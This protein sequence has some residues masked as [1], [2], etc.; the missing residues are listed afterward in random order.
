MGR[1]SGEPDL[2]QKMTIADA[3]FAKGDLVNL[4]SG[5]I[6]LAATGDSALVGVV[7]E[8]ISGGTGYE[9]HLMDI[10]G[11][12]PGEPLFKA[13]SYNPNLNFHPMRTETLYV[14]GLSE[15][16][17]GMNEY[18]IAQLDT[19][20]NLVRRSVGG[21]GG[22]I[23]VLDYARPVASPDDIWTDKVFDP[24]QKGQPRFAR[25]FGMANILFSD[26][27]VRAE[28]PEDIDPIAPTAAMKWWMP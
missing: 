3:A 15:T 14:G 12:K 17:Y 26:G 1:L 19:L 9:D 4:E 22:K 18:A 21:A 5:Q 25:H 6:D 10:T 20:G 23:L 28:R 16:S 7:L 27:S 8:S 13:S 11:G 24:D 2:I